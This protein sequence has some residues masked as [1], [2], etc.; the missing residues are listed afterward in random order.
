[1]K[2]GPIGYDLSGAFLIV[3]CYQ[4]ESDLDRPKKEKEDQRQNKRKLN[5]SLR[6]WRS[7]AHRYQRCATVGAWC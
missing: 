2:S 7:L 1:V 5:E 6:L 4:K 3:L